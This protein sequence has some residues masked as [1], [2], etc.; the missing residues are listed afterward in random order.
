MRQCWYFR[1]AKTD[2][3][4]DLP[5]PHCL[6]IYRVL[7]KRRRLIGCHK[8]SAALCL[9]DVSDPP[10]HIPQLLAL[11][12]IHTSSLLGFPES[13]CNPVQLSASQLWTEL[14]DNDV[15]VG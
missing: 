9:F 5:R 11:A 10:L 6:A 4:L 1:V 13:V 3:A 2:R 15:S 14:Y 8:S 12:H 7:M